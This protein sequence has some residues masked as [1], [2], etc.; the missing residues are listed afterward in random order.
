[1]YGELYEVTFPVHGYMSSVVRPLP[2]PPPIHGCGSARETP[3]GELQGLRGARGDVSA[4]L[5]H[6]LT[7]ETP[8]W[9]PTAL[10]GCGSAQ[11]RDRQT[12]ARAT[13]APHCPFCTE[14]HSWST[15][16]CVRVTAP[17]LAFTSF[18]LCLITPLCSYL[19]GGLHEGFYERAHIIR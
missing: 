9:G 7:C 11:L 6:G 10:P 14:H 2:A 17:A 12:R 5:T 3:P 15:P 19:Y 1:L 8:P 13:F 4:A 18:F 16:G